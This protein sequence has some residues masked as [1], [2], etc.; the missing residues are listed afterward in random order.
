MLMQLVCVDRRYQRMNCFNIRELQGILKRRFFTD[1]VNSSDHRNILSSSMIGLRYKVNNNFNLDTDILSFHRAGTTTSTKS[2]LT[3]LYSN[4][5][6]I[7]SIPL[8]TYYI[9]RGYATVNAPINSLTMNYLAS[10][11]V[12]LYLYINSFF[13]LFN[14]SVFSALQSLFSINIYSYMS[15]LLSFNFR[16]SLIFNDIN[17]ANTVKDH[18]PTTS[19]FSGKSSFVMYSDIN[20]YAYSEQESLSRF[21]RFTNPTLSYDYKCGHYIGI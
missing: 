1:M 7:N 11:K 16:P 3:D 21:S 9:N 12:S 18:I 15:T 13:L 8:T 5:S 14:I 10:F 19:L 17:N 4:Y 20:T 2:R 6:N